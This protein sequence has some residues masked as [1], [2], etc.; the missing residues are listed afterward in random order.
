MASERLVRSVDIEQCQL[1]AFDFLNKFPQLPSHS[2]HAVIARLA[3]DFSCF[4]ENVLALQEPKSL[5][6]RNNP[7]FLF[8]QFYAKFR[9]NALYFLQT[10]LKVFFAFVNQI[11][12]VHISSVI[13]DSQ[14]F[15]AEMV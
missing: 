5:V 8:V 3:N 4:R 11:N 1:A 10:T 9:A 14:N 13:F 15:L 2:F 6:K 7:R 12:V